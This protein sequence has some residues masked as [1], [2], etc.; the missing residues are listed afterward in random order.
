MSWSCLSGFALQTWE[1]QQTCCP[2]TVPHSSAN[3]NLPRPPCGVACDSG[4]YWNSAS[5]T[6][7][8]CPGVPPPGFAW[9]DNCSTTFDC[10]RYYAQEG[11][12]VPSNSHWPPAAVSP[13][14]CVWLCNVG[15]VQNGELCC[16]ASA[17]L[18][19]GYGASGREWTQGICAMQ[20]SVGL[21]AAEVEQSCVPC[22]KYLAEFGIDYCQRSLPIQNLPCH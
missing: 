18:T 4:Y 19:P 9:G 8:L 1:N 6:C 15:Y 20:C 22:E 7:A 5:F 13:A 12:T 10:G 2:L 14:Q 11:M 21:F 16:G 17:A 3:S